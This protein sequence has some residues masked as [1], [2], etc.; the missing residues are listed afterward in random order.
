LELKAV[1]AEDIIARAIHAAGSRNF[2]PDGMMDGLARTLDALARVPLTAKARDAVYDRMVADLATRLRIEQWH[3]EHPDAARA[4][5]AGPVL[6][7]GMPRT[8]TTATVAMLALDDRFRFLRMWE[9]MEPLP[10]PVAGEEQSDPRAVAA[11]IAAES[12][13]KADMHLMNPDGPE[14]DLVFLAGLNMRAFHGALPMPDDFLDWWMDDDFAST[15]AYHA[16]VLQLL[17]SRRPP[18]LW[19]LKAPPHLFKLDAFARQYPGAKFIMTHRD[20][21][22][23][24]PS[25][26]SLNHA[27][28]SERCEADKLDKHRI[29]ATAL[30]FWSEGIRRGMA[31]RARIGEDRFI[32]VYNDDV[33]H[34]PVGTFEKVYAHLGMDLTADMRSRITDYGARNAPGA[35]GTHR[36]TLEE[37]GLT[38]ESVASAFRDYCERFDF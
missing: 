26:A 15:Y 2:G 36:Y 10:P 27:L 3:G 28:H 18:N 1:T 23:I 6:V 34:N 9:G 4:E 14:E 38:E 30:R 7:C 12:Y 16:R 8:G 20:P 22:K 24:I 31:A 35:F 25:L 32:D 37:Y 11:R 33:V 5:I 29:G 21:R 19:L 17:Q 13:A